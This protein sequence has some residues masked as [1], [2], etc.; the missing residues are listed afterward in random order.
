VINFAA[1]FVPVSG[2]TSEAS[3]NRTRRRVQSREG[4]LA[5]GTLRNFAGRIHGGRGCSSL[6][7]P[8]RPHQMRERLCWLKFSLLICDLSVQKSLKS[9]SKANLCPEIN[10]STFAEQY[11]RAGLH[12]AVA[13]PNGAIPSCWLSLVP[14]PSGGRALGLRHGKYRGS[15]RWSYGPGFARRIVLRLLP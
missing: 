10:R 11:V 5:Q 15:S 14:V 13:Q 3:S 6:P 1:P 8:R 12:P 4:V 2:I 7:L 9:K